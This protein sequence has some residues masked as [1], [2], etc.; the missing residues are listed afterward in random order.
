MP[1][2]GKKKSENPC[3]PS[4]A[5]GKEGYER[6]GKGHEPRKRGD[7]LGADIRIYVAA[8]DDDSN[9]SSEGVAGYQ[10]RCQGPGNSTFVKYL[11]IAAFWLV[12]NVNDTFR[13][14]EAVVIENRRS[15]FD[16]VRLEAAKA[17]AGN[18]MIDKYVP[19]IEPDEE[20]VLESRA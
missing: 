2:Y 16:E 18:R 1:D 3:N 6:H 7:A 14:A 15:C 19:R 20:T 11:E 5:H 12:G 4:V 8:G 13:L 10:Q 9:C 17:N